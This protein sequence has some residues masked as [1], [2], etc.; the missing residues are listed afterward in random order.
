MRA[1]GAESS[2]SRPKG[3]RSEIPEMTEGRQYMKVAL[4]IVLLAGILGFANIVP[5]LTSADEPTEEHTM[6]FQLE[7]QGETALTDVR[8]SRIEVGDLYGDGC[9]E[10]I[11]E[12]NWSCEALSSKGGGTAGVPK[13]ELRALRL[14]EQDW[15]WQY[16]IRYLG[17]LWDVDVLGI[18]WTVGDTDN[19]GKDEI[20]VFEGD[21]LYTHEWNG[22]HFQKQIFTF[23]HVG[24]VDQA[25]VGD[26]DGE[27]G[28]ELIT[29]SFHKTADDI[30]LIDQE[31]LSG[32]AYTLAVWR[33]GEDG[34]E[35]V[36]Q[37]S[38]G[39]GYGSSGLIPP[40]MLVTI[41]DIENTAR[42]QL[43]IMRAQS[44][45]SES[46]F[47]FLV[48]QEGALTLNKHIVLS[49]ERSYVSGGFQ[50]IGW[51]GKV[52]LL[53]PTYVDR[54]QEPMRIAPAII[55]WRKNWYRTLRVSPEEALDGHRLSWIDP[56]GK[57]KGLLRLDRHGRYSFYRAN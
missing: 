13:A 19:D 45:V 43:V 57:G 23:P 15:V 17:N 40:D 29:L 47:D 49:G 18:A 20:L 30:A 4:H 7:A 1:L 52:Y 3:G 6:A 21:T 16:P 25:I 35:P 53:I 48:W 37:D 2:K 51:R 12:V 36:W 5:E 24:I 50:P 26:L 28:N 44:D 41:E 38:K 10:I 31:D 8:H 33:L 54:S 34:Y 32:P 56:D 11:A 55:E 14:G 39:M 27:D 9:Q 46:E 42:N 22:R